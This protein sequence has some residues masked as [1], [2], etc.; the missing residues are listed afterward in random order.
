MA[1]LGLPTVG[2]K[3]SD[4]FS[5][6]YCQ[7]RITGDIERPRASPAR[8]AVIAEP[9]MHLASVILFAQSQVPGKV[10]GR[11]AEVEMSTTAVLYRM[12]SDALKGHPRQTYRRHT[13]Y[14][15]GHLTSDT[16]QH[17]VDFL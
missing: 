5:L 2:V 4:R 10:P 1:Q 7:S 8:P 14:V 13:M 16:R 9:K 3:K 17:S 12:T 6:I 15:R 11:G